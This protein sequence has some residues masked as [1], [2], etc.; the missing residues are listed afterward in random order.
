MAPSNKMRAQ[1]DTSF[2]FFVAAIVALI[3]AAVGL[4]LTIRVVWSRFLSAS[5]KAERAPV[6]FYPVE[7]APPEPRLE[8]NP[9]QDLRDLHKKEDALL[10][11][12]RWIDKPK[13][14]VQI[15]VDRAIELL[16]LRGLPARRER[17]DR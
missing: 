6:T 15:P 4:D 9:L 11:S 12:Y 16:A 7:N 8:A 3:I 5:L 2:R 17:V 10:N 1:T 14:I 13:G